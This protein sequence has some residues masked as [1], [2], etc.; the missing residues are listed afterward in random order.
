MKIYC[1]VSCVSFM[2]N[3][4]FY[5]LPLWWRNLTAVRKFLLLQFIHHRSHQSKHSFSITGTYR[6]RLCVS[7]FRTMNIQHYCDVKRICVVGYR[8][9]MEEIGILQL[10]TMYNT[11]KVIMSMVLIIWT[12][13][14]WMCMRF[15]R[16]S[17]YRTQYTKRRLYLLE[18]DLWRNNEWSREG[19]YV[20]LVYMKSTGT[21]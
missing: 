15:L 13:F 12:A 14:H 1:C 10:L 6:F 5:W 19:K 3:S 21:L 2:K 18:Y 17:L 7:V 16:A 8:N 4:I 9:K 20:K 11:F